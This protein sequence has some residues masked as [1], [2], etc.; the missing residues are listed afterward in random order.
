MLPTPF[1]EDKTMFDR[2]Q[3]KVTFFRNYKPVQEIRGTALDVY[4]KARAWE[5]QGLGAVRIVRHRGR[6]PLSLVDLWCLAEREAQQ[7]DRDIYG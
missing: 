6:R 7:R 3:F 2:P 1:L 5:A 4:E